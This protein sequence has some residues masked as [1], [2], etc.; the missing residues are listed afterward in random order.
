MEEQIESHL[1][2]YDLDLRKTHN[3]RFMDQKLTPDNLS[4][5]CDCIRNYTESDKSKWFTKKDIWYSQYLEVNVIAIYNKPNPK[6]PSAKREYDKFVGQPLR[7]LASAGILEDKKI[8]LQY[9]Y[10]IQN[11][12]LLDLLAL[13]Q[14][15]S[16]R[17]LGYYL[18]KVLSDS[19]ELRYFRSYYDKYVS[20]ILANEDLI[21]LR[22]RYSC[23]IR[24]NT[25]IR[26]ALE[27]NR[28]FN[29]IFNILAVLWRMPGEKGGK[30]TDYPMIYKDIEYNDINWRDLNK[31][32]DLTRKQSML[33]HEAEVK[34]EKITDY[35]MI[36]AKAAIK[37]RHM[38]ASELH[39]KL[40]GG[41]AT[42]AHHIFP[43]KVFPQY[44]STLENIILLTG[45]QHN[46]RAHP[47]NNT[48]VVDLD[49]QR[50]CLMSKLDSI[51]QSEKNKDGF[52][53]LVKFIE[54]LNDIKGYNLRVDSTVNQVK[55][56]LTQA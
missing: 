21:E 41:E 1:S 11:Y 47:S 49:Y 15:N 19:G 51:E 14:M 38:L 28:I 5:I 33:L 56:K 55:D 23:F 16:L 46:S 22:D 6:D 44:R 25:G 7:L 30:I 18:T 2:K 45:S 35:E 39:D 8:G 36:K 53:S 29:K 48:Q 12:E 10:K 32:K 42:Q 4:F 13:S 37:S 43:D 31:K 20:K 54:M 17:F 52:Y 27:P 40:A 50:Q 24:G 26:G 34:H 9:H 3:G